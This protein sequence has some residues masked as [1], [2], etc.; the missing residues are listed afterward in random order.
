MNPHDKL[1][2]WH[3]KNTQNSSTASCG[4]KSPEIPLTEH[5]FEQVL[6]LMRRC[7]R[8]G[9]IVVPQGPWGLW[10]SPR[11]ALPEVHMGRQIVDRKNNHLNFRR[12]PGYRHTLIKHVGK[13]PR[14]K[15]GET[16]AITCGLKPVEAYSQPCKTNYLQERRDIP[17][18]AVPVLKNCWAVF[19]DMFLMT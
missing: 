13:P 18:S 19:C 17:L 14:M 5:M 8:D 12:R 16:Q 4:H 2:W 3:H 10:S 7:H 11:V 15:I 9:Q 6:S 1:K